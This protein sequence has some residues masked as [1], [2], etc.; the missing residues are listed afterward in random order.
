[1]VTTN[2][3]YFLDFDKL[4]EN[5]AD[6]YYNEHSADY[7][8]PDDF[9]HDLDK[10]YHIWATSPQDAI[11]GIS[12]SE[13]FNRIPTEELPDI[14]RGACIG[15]RNP[16]SLLFDRIATEPSLLPE[17]EKLAEETTDEK[18][19]TVTLSIIDELGGA[20][21]KFYL[22]MIER[23]VDDAVKE[24]CVGALCERADRVKNELLD[25]AEHTDDVNMIEIYAEPLTFCKAGDDRILELLRMLLGID[26]NTAYIAGLTARYGD[27]RAAADLYALLDD[28]DYPTFLELRNAIETLG[29]SVDEHYRD[30]TDD[31]SYGI[32]KGV[33]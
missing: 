11:G 17:L 29:G 1:M 23:D 19:L 20:G 27:E 21:D 3:L 30:F 18:L 7:E 8:S 2:D 5:Y 31:P 10:V 6:K 28:C 12:P 14:L 9:A 16:S 4:F 13:F 22:D 15:D 24:M 26:P 25:R 33:K 32:L